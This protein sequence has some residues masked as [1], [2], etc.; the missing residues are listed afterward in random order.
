MNGAESIVMAYVVNSLWQVPLIMLAAWMAARVVRPLG[1]GAEH[2]VWVAALLGE[3]MVPAISLLPWESMEVAWPWHLHAQQAEQ[4]SVMVQVG[5]G[6]ASGGMAIPSVLVAAVTGLYATGMLYVAARFAWRWMRLADLQQSAQAVSLSGVA[7][8]AWERGVQR[9]GAAS[10]ELAS[11]RHIFAPLTMGIAKRCVLLPAEMIADLAD[12]EME[13]VI[14]HE[15][16]HVKRMDFAKNVAY[17]LI[18]LAVSYHPAVWFTKQRLTETREM[19][20]DA[21]AA[22]ISGSKVYAQ[23][24]L[25][26]AELLLQGKTVRVPYAIGVFDS[27]TLERRLMKLTEMKMEIGHARRVMALGACVVLGVAAAT[28]AVAL[29][30]GVDQKG[31]G[32]KTASK[33]IPTSVPAQKM[34]NNLITKVPPVYP[35][36]AKA[37]RIQG[38]VVLNA[39]IGVDGHVENLKVVSGPKELQQ[40]SLD[41]VRQWVYKPY[42]VNGNPVEVT[43]DINVIYSLAK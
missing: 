15:L 34:Q 31:S 2:R 28:S 30:V 23:S 1:P 16:A 17:E 5:G 9:I 26:L 29:R 35:P 43:T 37:A 42:T 6:T 12:G 25:R 7:G 20:C 40:S 3:A 38:K 13:T 4:G 41:A 8:I 24:L 39:V 32:E 14:G 19:I 27:S 33:S 11:S 18:S 36:E 21:M 22:E 10:V